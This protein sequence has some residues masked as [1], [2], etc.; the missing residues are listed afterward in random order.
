M[1]H[2]AILVVLKLLARPSTNTT[3]TSIYWA[4]A[5]HQACMKNTAYTWVYSMWQPHVVLG[6]VFFFKIKRL[7]FIINI[8]LLTKRKFVINKC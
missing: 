3:S 2:T 8:S 4:L 7:M 1:L 6:E 5:L